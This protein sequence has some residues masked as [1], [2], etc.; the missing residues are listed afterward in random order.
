MALGFR[1][2]GFSAVP[3]EI[4][5]PE[6]STPGFALEPPE[7]KAGNEACWAPLWTY[8]ISR[9]GTWNFVFLTVIL[10]K[11]NQSRFMEW[12]LGVTELEHSS[13]A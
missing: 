6:R 10:M 13:L 2:P 5:G 12:C 7:D 3:Q 1:L 11:P 4:Q 8:G 9:S